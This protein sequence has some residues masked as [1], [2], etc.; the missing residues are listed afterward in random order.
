M[1]RRFN[2]AAVAVIAVSFL[3]IGARPFTPQPSSL[4]YRVKAAYLVNFAK[5]IDWPPEAFGSPSEAFTICL[6]GDPFNGALERTVEGEI[7]DGRRIVIRRTNAGENL[8][9]C[10]IVFVS[11]SE[12]KR[13]IEI[14]NSVSNLPILT[15]G[16]TGDFIKSGGMIRFFEAANR[17]QFQ[18]N[19]EAAE[20]ASLRVSSRLLRL[21]DIVKG[22]VLEAER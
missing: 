9:R 12:G 19:P 8:R 21:A 6:A 18:I 20:R 11:E 2:W 7:L 15:V 3:L 10:H 22:P 16:D 1:R 14:I 17:V 5:F 13:S 4:V